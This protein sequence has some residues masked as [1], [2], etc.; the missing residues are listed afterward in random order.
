MILDKYNINSNFYLDHQ[1]RGY[2]H[3]RLPSHTSIYPPYGINPPYN[4][5]Y[6][7]D[8]IY[9]RL[10]PFPGQP[11]PLGPLGRPTGRW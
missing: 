4:S 6:H 9:N 3:Y 7:Q 8:P 1:H 11:G 10:N 5:I 2:L